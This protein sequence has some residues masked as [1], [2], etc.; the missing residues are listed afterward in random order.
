MNT[1]DDTFKKLK[2]I[3]F[4]E[5][6]IILERQLLDN[7]SNYVATGRPFDVSEIDFETYGWTETE[8]YSV[9]SSIRLSILD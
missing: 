1:E 4:E 6:K 8:F 3:S 9:R 5:M 7:I 2:R